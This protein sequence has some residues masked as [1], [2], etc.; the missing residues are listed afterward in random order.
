M[1][2]RVTFDTLDPKAEIFAELKSGKYEWWENVKA[3]PNLYIEIRKDNS[4]N[5]YYQG[6]SVMRLEYGRKLNAYTHRKYLYG[7][8]NGYEECADQLNIK[9]DSIIENIPRFYSQRKGTSKEKWSEKFIQG[10]YILNYHSQFIDSEFAYKENDLDIRIDL[11]ECIAGE[12]RFVELKRIDDNRMVTSDMNPEIITQIN[13]YRKFISSHTEEIIDYYKRLYFIK[14]KLGLPV[15]YG[16]PSTVNSE[17]LLLIFDR[18]VKETDGRTIHRE[19]MEEILEKIAKPKIDYKIINSFIVP[20]RTFYFSEQKR[21][22]DYYKHFLKS[23]ANNGGLFNR[24]ARDFVL[25]EK[26][27]SYNLFT[28]IIKSPDSAIDYF[29]TYSIAWWGENAKKGLPSGHLV[30]SQIH[31]LNHLFALRLDEEAVRTIVTNATGLEIAKVLPSPLDKDGY[32][33]F[34]FVF[35]NISLL[36]E[37]HETRGA[38]CT[39]I[40]ALVYVE[41]INGD[42]LL[43]PIEWKYTETYD[44]SE[45]REESFGR[46]TK[47]HKDSNCEKWSS[48]YRADP[49][50]ELMRQTLLVEHIVKTKECGLYADDY[51]H[52]VVCP[53]GNDELLNDIQMFRETLSSKGKKRFH[54]I[55][56]Q[57]LLAPLKGNKNYTKLLNYL[58]TRYWHE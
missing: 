13:N 35:K 27:S 53:K 55:D 36:G 54:I 5:V 4:I 17:P 31:C 16:I 49:F 57:D 41:L 58:K 45:A 15:P 11:V 47:R 14:K 42:K 20:Q 9:L 44:R 33:T 51:A 3:N 48:L 24:K 8:G 32:I 7:T 2:K 25:Q 22:I 21:Q 12:I 26:D 30:S 37:T 43:V 46:Y 38:N 10:Q 39:S 28:D 56:P 40:D 52:I 6:G 50:Y 29:S 1:E 34:E 18:W 19:M 23:I